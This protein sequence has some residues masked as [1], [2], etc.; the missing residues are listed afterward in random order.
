M[1]RA[2]FPA[3]ADWPQFLQ[4]Y[5]RPLPRYTSYPPATVWRDDPMEAREQIEEATAAADGV[6]LYI[7]IPF[8]PSLR[9]YC[10]C[11]RFITKDAAL[12]DGYLDAVGQEL[13][14]VVDRVG[15]ARVNWLHWAAARPRAD[16]AP[17]LYIRQPPG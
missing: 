11:N 8:C 16:M 1:T 7:H 12:V 3:E 14:A 10:A 4:C 9:W 2:S 17:L 13:D 15:P 5:D 6:A